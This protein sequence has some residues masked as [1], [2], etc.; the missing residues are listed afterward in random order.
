MQKV[1]IGDQAKFRDKD[2]ILPQVLFPVRAILRVKT[3][4]NVTE[5]TQFV[6]QAWNIRNVQLTFSM[7]LWPFYLY[8]VNVNRPFPGR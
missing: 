6:P 3:Q 2:K 1:K 7:H 8:L 5:I 4:E